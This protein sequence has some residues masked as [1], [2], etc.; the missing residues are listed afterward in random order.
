MRE[1]RKQSG[2]QLPR[3]PKSDPPARVDWSKLAGYI[4]AQA[5]KQ[6]ATQA[7]LLE[8]RRHV[9]DRFELLEA[10]VSEVR[11]E[12]RRMNEHISNGSLR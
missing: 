5:S 12:T 6:A 8:M 9:D 1:I 4:E 3:G 11:E 2:A 10:A 7:D